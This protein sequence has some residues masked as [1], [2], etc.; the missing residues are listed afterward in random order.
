MSSATDLE[1]GREVITQEAEALQLLSSQ[2]GDAFTKAIE[3]ILGLRGR[4]IVTGMGKSGHVGNK[5]AAT[6]ASTG[7]PS[8][9]VHPGEASHG[10]LGMIG[11]DD[12]LLA[13]SNS[14]E[15]SELS[16]VLAHARRLS[17]PL[18]TITGREDST[19]SRMADHPLVLPKVPEACPNGL[20]PTSSTTMAMALGDALAVALMK[21][22]MFAAEDFFNLHPGGRLGLKFITVE[23]LM[24]GGDEL[25]R[26]NRNDGLDQVLLEITSKTLG[27]TLVMD[28]D[29]CQG[30]ITDGD[31]RRHLNPKLFEKRAGDIMTS[32]P[33]FVHKDQPAAGALGLMQDKGI[34]VV[35]VKDD[36]PEPVGLLHIHDCLRAG[37]G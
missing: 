36:G 16:D 11:R 8:F 35:L 23:S 17:I 32:N 5:I 24:H 15:T 13:L 25:P 29:M 2:L 7:Q 33:I 27:C 37:L 30:I 18:I 1:T 3:A 12:G 10:D 14:G 19:M 31:L 9:F 20:A 21:R 6:L 34:T 28:H 22:R 4:L 26:V